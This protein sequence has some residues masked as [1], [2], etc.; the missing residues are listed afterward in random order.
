MSFKN[1]FSS[2]KFRLKF[3]L[4]LSSCLLTTSS[5]AIALPLTL[6]IKSATNNNYLLQKI[7]FDQNKR[8]LE[9]V[10]DQNSP[11]IKNN[12]KVILAFIPET[13]GQL[14]T[15]EINLKNGQKTYNLNIKNLIINKKYKVQYVKEGQN[16]NKAPSSPF[17]SFVIEPENSS[18]INS[19]STTAV[20]DSK[21]QNANNKSNQT[22]SQAQPKLNPPTQS[23]SKKPKPEPPVKIDS[24]TQSDSNEPKPAN[25]SLD[26][27]PN[28]VD[29]TTSLAEMV[30]A[31]L[32]KTN[33]KNVK[34]TLDFTN[35]AKTNAFF[36]KIENKYP[37]L[38]YVTTDQ[39]PLA[40]S[41][42]QKNDQSQLV[43]HGEQKITINQT[44]YQF[45][46]KNLDVNQSYFLEKI[47]F[48]DTKIDSLDSENNQLKT[49]NTVL[50]DDHDQLV[51]SQ[52]QKE[53][54]VV[55]FSLIDHIIV[56]KYVGSAK[57]K[58]S[59]KKIAHD[60]TKNTS[61]SLLYKE[62]NHQTN[63]NDNET[64]TNSLNDSSIKKI[65]IN[66]QTSKN[67]EFVI[68]DLNLNTNYQIIDLQ[69]N[70]NDNS[71]LDSK[72]IS[73]NYNQE[74]N[75]SGIDLD[76]TTKNKTSFPFN[77]AL[78]AK[79]VKFDNF[80]EATFQAS[81][82]VEQ[83]FVNQNNLKYRITFW[84][85]NNLSNS[86]VIEKIYQT[87]NQTVQ[88]DNSVLYTISNS[89]SGLD[90]TKDQTLILKKLE[91][92][93]PDQSW[94]V[95]A[96]DHNFSNEVMTKK[97]V[98]ILSKEN[99]AKK[100]DNIIKT[101]PAITKLNGLPADY[102]ARI[103]MND[104]QI[105]QMFATH[106]LRLDRF[107]SG[108]RNRKD[109]IYLHYYAQYNNKEERFTTILDKVQDVI[110]S[111]DLRNFWTAK[112]S[113]E[114]YSF[115]YTY[116]ASWALDGNGRNYWYANRQNK[117]IVYKLISKKTRYVDYITVF[118]KNEK[119]YY[120]NANLKPSY[121]D[122]D[123]KR[124]T[125][126]PRPSELKNGKVAWTFHIRDFVKE[127]IITYPKGQQAKYTSITLFEIRADN[128][129]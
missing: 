9:A 112:A 108:S 111:Y 44:Q 79:L 123:G 84:Q 32:D 100:L 78:K 87:F 60:E 76:S 25:S 51:F 71:I 11:L 33:I 119:D 105:Q 37:T 103:T 20:V 24:P 114:G 95:V 19:P 53:Q 47:V 109:V 40:I 64:E 91:V 31:T 35:N 38:Y 23:K 2:K 8:K 14:V 68:S 129:Y 55:E 120:Q 86:N 67:L 59:L 118:T 36:R 30:H 115:P 69:Q 81:F 63:I 62:N 124:I 7:T 122:K 56:E 90:E 46:L 39:E 127:F 89:Q 85:K 10:F 42:Q 128:R 75:T 41:Q 18:T 21:N 45:N 4:G 74:I 82:V 5:I 65:T 1:K 17:L 80:N 27:T 99:Y 121:I 28:L 52:K 125:L 98:S 50:N 101:D 6:N 22:K 110:V 48:T 16:I 92:Q 54:L 77:F 43:V 107:V 73:L 72:N 104:S 12:A 113:S 116:N 66:N 88:N 49:K 83:N 97:E 15:N 106:N 3:F 34:L 94:L 57:V 29:S 117:D 58:V 70:I 26:P 93:K 13:G 96:D 61:Y 102:I 126:S